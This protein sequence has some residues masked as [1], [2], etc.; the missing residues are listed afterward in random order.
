ML[1]LDT[2]K[3]IQENAELLYDEN[4]IDTALTKVANQINTQLNNKNP[5]VICVINGGIITAGN[6]LPKLNFPLTLDSVHVSRYAHNT[7]GDTLKWIAKPN[8]SLADRTVLVVDDI[9]DE[10]ITLHEITTFCRNQGAKEIFSAVLVDKQLNK[11]KPIT[12][13]F[14]ALT[15]PN[16]FLFGYGMDYQGYL[17]NAPGIFA[18]QDL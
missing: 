12:A 6:L 11:P 14:I 5:L 2:L 10:G 7:Y 15:S 1:T 17:R 8:S 16:R 3:T 13:D 4:Q 18:C 9:L